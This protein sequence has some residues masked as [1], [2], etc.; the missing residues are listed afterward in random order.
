MNDGGEA[1]AS[2]LKSLDLV[3]HAQ[4]QRAASFSG[5]LA[6]FRDFEVHGTATRDSWRR[7]DVGTRASRKRPRNRSLDPAQL[8]FDRL[9]EVL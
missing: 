5:K 8:L 1:F 3:E 6:M 7:G 2:G 9:P 4:P